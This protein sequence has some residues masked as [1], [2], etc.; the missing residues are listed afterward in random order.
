MKTKRDYVDVA[1]DMLL[2]IVGDDDMSMMSTLLTSKTIYANTK[3]IVNRSAVDQLFDEVIDIFSKA[4]ELMKE[5]EDFSD[6]S[7]DNA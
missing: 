1:L 6:E 2:N 5:K 7:K 4:K 3:K